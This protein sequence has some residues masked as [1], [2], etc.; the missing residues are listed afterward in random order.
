MRCVAAVL[1]LLALLLA[2]CSGLGEREQ[3]PAAQ[4]YRHAPLPGRVSLADSEATR[5]A[6]LAQYLDWAGVPYRLGGNTREG[7]DCSG[8]IQLTYLQ[9]FGIALPRDT[10]AQRHAGRLV[11]DARLRPG[12]LVFFDTTARERHVGIYLG[13]RQF[14]HVS[15]RAGVMLS[16]LDDGYWGARFTHAVRVP[17]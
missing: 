1:S 11:G 2:G 12:D 17:P 14:L 7:T 13:K 16:R 5:A 6:L 3:S 8:F 4:D 10:S 15:T 9:R